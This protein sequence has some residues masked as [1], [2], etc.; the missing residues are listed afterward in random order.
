MTTIQQIASVYSYSFAQAE[1]E[2]KTP[3]QYFAE[4]SNEI[5]TLSAGLNSGRFIPNGAG[6]LIRI[7]DLTGL[8]VRTY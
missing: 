2:R 7:R 3:E 1:R 6:V 8:R 5:S 4:L